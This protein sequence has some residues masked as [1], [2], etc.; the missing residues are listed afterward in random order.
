MR[1]FNYCF[2]LACVL[3]ACGSESSP[4]EPTDAASNV[5]QVEC[6]PA[7]QSKPPT[8]ECIGTGSCL[9]MVYAKCPDGGSI[10]HKKFDCECDGSWA[11]HD[12]G[13][14]LSF[15]GVPPMDAGASD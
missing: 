3:S 4:P 1:F 7:P 13:N 10:P 6:P 12:L 11:C 8:G 9:V 5:V 15:C 2:G 14:T